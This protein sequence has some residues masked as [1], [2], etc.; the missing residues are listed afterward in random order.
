MNVAIPILNNDIA[1]CFEAAR[2]FRIIKTEQSG[3]QSTKSFICNVNKGFDL[4]KLLQIH[5]TDI[6]ICN[7]IKD[8]LKDQLKSN[9]I[10]VISDVN[11]PIECVI[12]KLL[13]GEL[14]DKKRSSNHLNEYYSVIHYDLVMW[15]EKL[16]RDN[17]FS[18]TLLHENESILTDFV[19]VYNCP[20]CKKPIRVAVCCGAQMYRA[21]YE[22][23]EFFYAVHSN[24]DVCAYVYIYDPKIAKCCSNYGIEY[25]C[26]EDFNSKAAENND[27]V[28]PIL[29]NP[30]RTHNKLIPDR[31]Q[32]IDG[33]IV[34]N[35]N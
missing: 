12:D 34:T 18:V 1:P 22:I 20:V 17:G 5:K 7:G 11:D 10:E 8:Y 28:I 29:K 2:K 19:A 35:S 13:T 4:I 15:A 6:L 27:D 33:G 3:I 25:I 23:R 30:I 14:E 31:R 16:F 21:D 24:Y 26:T 32:S 9:G